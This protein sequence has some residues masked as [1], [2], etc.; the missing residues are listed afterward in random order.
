[1]FT[2]DDTVISDC[3][4]TFSYLA[5]A[6]EEKAIDYIAQSDVVHQICAALESSEP[7]HFVPAMKAIG[8]ILTSNEVAVIDR[9]LWCGCIEKLAN[10][11]KLLKNTEIVR[12][13]CWAL[14]NITASG[15][16]HVAQ[17]V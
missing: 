17:F 10:L 14:S 1:M 16:Q 3:L 9:C 2:T 4:W 12:E 5:E 7:S 15:N 13:G 8:S 6:D 11:I